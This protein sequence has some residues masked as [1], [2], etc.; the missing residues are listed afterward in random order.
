ME[1]QRV[2]RRSR[3]QH[4]LTIVKSACKSTVVHAFNASP[5]LDGL[6]VSLGGRPFTMKSGIA[7]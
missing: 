4:V 5:F 2:H 6:V 3:L 1:T 7:R